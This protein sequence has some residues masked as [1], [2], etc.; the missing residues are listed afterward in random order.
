MCY[1]CLYLFLVWQWFFFLGKK[2]YITAP[3]VKQCCLVS[4]GHKKFLWNMWLNLC[5]SQ[6]FFF[7]FSYGLLWHS[8][9]RSS[10]LAWPLLYEGHIRCY[11]LS[12]LPPGPWGWEQTSGDRARGHPLSHPWTSW[13][14]CHLILGVGRE[15]CTSLLPQP[16][17][18]DQGVMRCYQSAQEASFH[19][20]WGVQW[21]VTQ[22]S[23]CC[24]G[25]LLRIKYCQ[26]V[27]L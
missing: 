22:I 14:R 9:P 24:L 18:P 27:Y 11:W 4:H 25:T 10:P 17:N 5:L 12:Q 16:R 1:F 19:G 8:K 7:F 3:Y 23:L 26:F 2:I 15:R 6:F 21:W 20:R 13:S